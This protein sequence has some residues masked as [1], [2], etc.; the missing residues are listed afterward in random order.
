MNP[1]QAVR[2]SGRR[3]KP[4]ETE[5]EGTEMWLVLNEIHRSRELVRTA[6]VMLLWVFLAALPLLAQSYYGVV[7]GLVTDQKGG[8]LVTAKVTIIN[9][10]T[11]EQRST[12]TS[13]NGEYHFNEVGPAT[14]MV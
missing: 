5:R 8:A 2:V 12:L 3:A 6:G 10:G 14:S 4:I 1:L 7:R 13:S 11:A 9:E